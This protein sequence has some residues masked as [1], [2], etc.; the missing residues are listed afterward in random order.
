MVALRCG[1]R[2]GQAGSRELPLSHSSIP[3]TFSASAAQPDTLA[4]QHKPQQAWP[5]HAKAPIFPRGHSSGFLIPPPNPKIFSS[6]TGHFDRFFISSGL[7]GPR[8]DVRF[9]DIAANLTQPFRQV[10]SF[11]QLFRKNEIR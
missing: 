2:Q 10:S 4:Y 7:E 5:S 1:S 6:K 3:C 8:T 9:R 11:C